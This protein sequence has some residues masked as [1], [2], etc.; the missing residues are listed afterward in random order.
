[1]TFAACGRNTSLVEYDLLMTLRG[2]Y[3]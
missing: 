1:V 2:L 3:D